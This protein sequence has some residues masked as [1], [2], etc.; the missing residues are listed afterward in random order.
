MYSYSVLFAKHRIYRI[1][2]HTINGRLIYTNP[3]KSRARSML[4]PTATYLHTRQAVPIYN[5]NNMHVC[6]E[7]PAK[8]VDLHSSKQLFDP[9]FER[10]TNQPPAKRVR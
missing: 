4:G 1:H 7:Q 8:I 3:S 6:K 10:L 2:T 5:I 9:F